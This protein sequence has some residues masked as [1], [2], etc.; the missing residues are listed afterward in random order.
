MVGFAKREDLGA[1]V[2]ALIHEEGPMPALL[3]RLPPAGLRDHSIRFLHEQSL[4]NHHFYLSDENILLLGHETDAVMAEY[5]RLEKHAV[6]LLV[7]YP[8][9]QRATE[10][11][12][13]FRKNYL[14]DGDKSG[15]AMLEDHSW[16]AAAKRKLL[17]TVVLEAGSRPLAEDLLHEVIKP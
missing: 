8:T 3:L 9:A 16:C 6:L 7:T 17:L 10:A 1:R 13:S 4:L 11:F 5:T 12:E 14:P 15:M 2:S